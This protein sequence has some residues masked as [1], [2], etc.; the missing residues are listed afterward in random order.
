MC[1][2]VCVERLAED[3]DGKSERVGQLRLANLVLLLEHRDGALIVV[4]DASRLPAA[5]V[6]RRIALIELEAELLIPAHVQ[7]G[8]AERSLAAVLCVGLLDVAQA[9]HEILGGYGLLVLQVVA[10]CDQTQ[11]VDQNVGV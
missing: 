3:L 10:L 1:Q 8:D 2:L 11:L 9:G 5:I 7:D 4:A 6:A